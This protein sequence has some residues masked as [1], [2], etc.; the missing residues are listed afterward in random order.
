MRWLPLDTEERVPHMR[1]WGPTSFFDFRW[2]FATDVVCS[3]AVIAELL[4][5][6][7]GVQ[8]VVSPK[9][10]CIQVQVYM[11]VYALYHVACMQA[12]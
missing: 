1:Q 10:L 12:L 3:R 9:H 5:G 11:P 4:S 8:S 7:V 6:W 2:S